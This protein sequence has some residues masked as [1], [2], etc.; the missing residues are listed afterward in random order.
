MV[1]H[2]QCEK[3]PLYNALLEVL[4]YYT[5]IQILLLFTILF[6]VL[7]IPCVGSDSQVSAN[8]IDKGKDHMVTIMCS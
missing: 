4:F 6:E 1:Q 3:R 8:L 2:M 5:Y 7:D